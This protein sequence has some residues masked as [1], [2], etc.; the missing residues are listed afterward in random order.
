MFV[1]GGVAEEVGLDHDGDGA[2]RQVTGK[3]K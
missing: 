2:D 3:L 1:A